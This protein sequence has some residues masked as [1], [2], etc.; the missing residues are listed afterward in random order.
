M[1]TTIPSNL[2]CIQILDASYNEYIK[3]IKKPS[4]IENISQ[5]DQTSQEVTTAL[6]N[7]KIYLETTIAAYD[8]ISPHVDDLA[9]GNAQYTLKVDSVLLLSELMDDYVHSIEWNS[10]DKN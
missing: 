7:R 10:I 8:S 6:N 4:N 9:F 5:R 1:D 3:I 2:Q